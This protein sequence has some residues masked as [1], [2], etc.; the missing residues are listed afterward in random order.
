MAETPDSESDDSRA[1][2]KIAPVNFLF[3]FLAALLCI[4]WAVGGHSTRHRGRLDNSQGDI[5]R[6]RI[7]AAPP[8]RAL[9]VS[10]ILLPRQSGR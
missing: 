3:L 2:W 9:D 1:K 6:G 5:F 8:W 7:L 10:S 4:S